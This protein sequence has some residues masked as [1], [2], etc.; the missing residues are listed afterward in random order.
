M[1]KSRPRAEI[2]FLGISHALG[3][4]EICLRG[5]LVGDIKQAQKR[6]A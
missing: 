2:P 6:A 5:R 3:E 1:M 4:G